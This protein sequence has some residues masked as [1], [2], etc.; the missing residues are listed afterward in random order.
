MSAQNERAKEYFE[1]R[2]KVRKEFDAK[3][4][5]FEGRMQESDEKWKNDTTNFGKAMRVGNGVLKGVFKIFEFFIKN[6]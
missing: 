4:I 5:E 6:T 2:K 1:N 3:A